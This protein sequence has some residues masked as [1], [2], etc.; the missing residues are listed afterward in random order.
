M[1][2]AVTVLGEVNPDSLGVVLPHEHLLW[3]QKCWG[4][5][6][7]QELGDREEFSKPVGLENRGRIV[8]HCFDYPDNLF[9]TDVEV[10]VAEARKFR[11]AGGG[12]ICEVSSAGLGRDP[13]ALYRIAVDTGL[14]IIMG[15]ALYVAGSWTEEEKKRS[16]QD[17]KKVLLGEFLD[18]VGPMR[19]KPGVLGEV[20]ISDI[21][22]PHEVKS[23]QG[24]AMAQKQ[25]G[26][27]ILIHT[28]I[29]EKAGNAILDV[30][31]EAGADPRRVALSHLDPTMADYDYADSLA[32]RGAYIVYD[33]FGMYLMSTEGMM[34]PSDTERIATLKEQ[35]KRGNLKNILI[36]QDVCFKIL[37]TKWGGHGYAHILENIVPRLR[38]EAGL[39]EEQI[40]T[41]LVENPKRFLSW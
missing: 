20:G 39:S 34:I 14:H 19:V 22:N 32:K 33:Q 3:D 5:P 31:Q 41:I 11:Q 6:A 37:L 24:S 1:A 27:P 9:Q 28:P 29:W 25:I 23:L 8:Y 36:S 2:K 35:V 18:G 13:K 17:I 12:T 10:A 15:S 40:H 21:R 16:P 38:R 26:C 7:P 4:H 30:L